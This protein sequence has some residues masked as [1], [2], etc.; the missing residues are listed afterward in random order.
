M[1]IKLTT[2]CL[3]IINLSPIEKH[4]LIVFC[5]RANDKQECWSSIDRLMI[6]TAYSKNTVEKFLKK[7]R[8]KKI[9]NYTGEYKG[10]SQRI[11]VYK[12]DLDH[13]TIWGDKYLITPYWKADHPTAEDDITP[14]CGVHKDNIK[15]NRK[16]NENHSSFSKPKNPKPQLPGVIDFQEHKAGKKGYEW[17]GE[18]LEDNKIT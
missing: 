16:D 2:L 14:P 4:L 13:P 6:D 11:P 18:W 9:L 10:S 12:I 17:V 8:D 5:F 7:L 3:D 1:S 15:N